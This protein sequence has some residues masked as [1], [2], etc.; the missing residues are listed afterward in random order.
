M[1]TLAFAPWARIVRASILERLSLRA[2]STPKTATFSSDVLTVR[3]DAS[4]STWY[5]HFER[6]DGAFAMPP[7]AI[8]QRTAET[9]RNV[10]RTVLGFFDATL[11]VADA[12]GR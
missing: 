4:R 2:T 10:A 3:I 8:D 5:V 11:S 7:L 9:A 6:H 1:D 12:D